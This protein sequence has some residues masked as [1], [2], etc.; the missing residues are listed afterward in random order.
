MEMTTLYSTGGM[1]SW[2]CV[3]LFGFFLLRVKRKEKHVWKGKAASAMDVKSLECLLPR[4]VHQSA[5]VDE[6]EVVWWL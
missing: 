5:V 3:S 6:R 4:Y 1:S 2:I